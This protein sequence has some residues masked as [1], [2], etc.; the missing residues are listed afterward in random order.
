MLM[1]P[2]RYLLAL[3]AI[4][5]VLTAACSSSDGSGDGSPAEAADTGASGST[6]SSS[7][8]GGTIDDDGGNADPTATQ[9]T[10]VTDALDDAEQTQYVANTGGVGVS[11]RSACETDARIDGSWPEGTELEVV[12]DAEAGCEDWSLLSDGEITSWVA[13]KYLSD[14]QPTG[15][16]TTTASS[17][18]TRQIEVID[19]FGN[20][21]PVSQL[22]VR[23]AT[24]TY[25]N[26]VFV[27]G[28]AES[29]HPVG[30]SAISTAG[31]IIAN[32]APKDCGFGAISLVPSFWVSV[33]S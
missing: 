7:P 32:P 14:T 15:R 13:N 3:V 21:I 22:T 16:T 20:L 31:K 9:P 30:D 11:L 2:K 25:N 18:T 8:V 10:W 5:A 19:F 6:T 24:F 4:F 23:P 28:C 12:L 26:A 27:S 17:G 1:T 33:S 29:W